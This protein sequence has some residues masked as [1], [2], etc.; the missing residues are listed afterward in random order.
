MHGNLRKDVRLLHS[1]AT[2]IYVKV[3]IPLCITIIWKSQKPDKVKQLRT[4]AVL[5]QKKELNKHI[6]VY[7]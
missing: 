3:H 4:W 7:I 5:E 6:P 1:Y 2:Q